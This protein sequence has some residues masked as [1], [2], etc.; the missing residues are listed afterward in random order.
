MTDQPIDV[1]HAGALLL[2]Q[3]LRMQLQWQSLFWQMPM[4]MCGAG[5]MTVHAKHAP[6]EVVDC[7]A[8]AQLA[9]PAD[10]GDHA[11]FA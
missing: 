8:H 2:S 4:T 5:W 6:A 1:P 11:L 7:T 3:M 9:I 10:D